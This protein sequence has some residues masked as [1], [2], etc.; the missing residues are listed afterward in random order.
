MYGHIAKMAEA[1][2]EGVDSVEGCEGVLFQ[3][4]LK[5]LWPTRPQLCPAQPPVLA[6]H[7]LSPVFSVAVSTAPHAI[8]CR[9]VALMPPFS[10][11]PETLP[12]EV[13]EKMGAPPKPDVPVI[14][15]AELPEYDGVIFGIPT[16]FGTPAGQ[17]KAFQDAC[18]QLW[19][20]GALAGKVTCPAD[21]S[22]PP[23]LH[24]AQ[25]QYVAAQ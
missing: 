19:A 9:R 8:Q 22:Q 16:R 10:Q 14:S 7:Q 24:R 5:N 23:S 17:V 20:K 15:P 6:L 13:L 1:V 18:G 11:V 25:C 3:V 12:T 2:K 4:R 21:R